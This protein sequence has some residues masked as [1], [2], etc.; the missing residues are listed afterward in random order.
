MFDFNAIITK[1][2]HFL[3]VATIWDIFEILLV[4]FLVYKLMTFIHNTSVERVLKGLLILLVAMP[5][6]EWLNL[7]VINFILRNTM[8]IGLVAI[9]IMFQPE[10]RRMLESVGGT[11]LQQIFERE[12]AENETRDMIRE[13]VDACSSMSWSRTGAL[14]V[15]ERKNSLS[16]I[17]TAAT[18]IDAKVSSQ[19]V[20]NI[21]FKNSPL[22]DGAMV[23]QNARVMLAGCVLPLSENEELSKDLGTR[24]RAGIGISEVSDAVSVMVS[25]ETGAVSIATRGVIR[26]GLSPE[27]LEKV[28]TKELITAEDTREKSAVDHIK[29][30]LAGVSPKNLVRRGRKNASDGK[31]GDAK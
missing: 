21:F 4:A 3:R 5:V 25:E 29:R 10:L 22:H 13:I 18:T 27:A 30:G 12:T 2:P 16:D 17:V 9:L 7:S 26:R 8:Q 14:I 19:L 6:S 31:G 24:H 28:L 23:I 1:L 15:F 20:R 11:G